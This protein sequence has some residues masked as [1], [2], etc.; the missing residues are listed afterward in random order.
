MLLLRQCDHVRVVFHAER[1]GATPG[2]RDHVASIAGAEIDHVV[3]RCDLREIEHLLDELWRR[4]HPHHVLARLPD[5]RL[6]RLDVLRGD[7]NGEGE[8]EEKKHRVQ[9]PADRVDI[10]PGVCDGGHAT[11]HGLIQL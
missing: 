9:F 7:G 11:P 1:V 3:L 10:T 2:G 4:G 6:E 8:G 5:H